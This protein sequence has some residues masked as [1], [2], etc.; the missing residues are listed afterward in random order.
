MASRE[1]PDKS[2]T[3]SAKTEEPAAVRNLQT[4]YYGPERRAA[5]NPRYFPLWNNAISIGGIFLIILAIILLLTFGLFNL[6]TPT[7]NP[8]VDIVGYLILPVLLVAGLLI[9]PVGI[10]FKSWRLHR[11]DPSQKLAFRFPRIDLNDPVQRRAAKFVVGLTFVMLPVA[12][13]SGYHG[14]HYTDSTE[15]CA[16]AC[17]SVMEPQATAYE[18]SPHARV[19]CAECH[20]GAGASWFVKSKLSGTRQVFATWRDSYQRPIPPAITHLRPAR[21]TCERCHW[22]KKFYGA[23]LTRIVNYSS[24]QNNTRAKIDM[25]LKIGGGDESSGRAEGIHMHMALAGRIDYIATDDKLQVI[26][27]VRMIDDNGSELIYRSDGRP[28]TDPLPEGRIRQ[29]DCM[30]CHNRPAHKFRSPQR[31]VDIYLDVGNIDT[32]LPYIKR[33]AVAVLVVDYPDVQSAKAQIGRHL[34]DFYRQNYPDIWQARKASVDQAIDKVR[35]IYSTNFFPDMQVDWQTYPDNIGHKNS[36]GCFRCHAGDHVNQYGERISHD[37]NIC[38]TFLNAVEQNDQGGLIQEGEF[39]HPVK[40]AGRH[41]DLRCHQCHSG[42]LAPVAT[43]EGCHEKQQGFY[44]ATLAQLSEFNIEKDPMFGS[45]GCESCHD[46]SE[47][48]SLE[49]VDMQCLDCHEDEEEEYEGLLARWSDD[50]IKKRVEA[51]SAMEELM[52]WIDTHR[53]D[54]IDGQAAIAWV[55]RSRP[56]VQLLA[57][58]GPLHNYAAAISIYE[59]LAAEATQY[60]TKLQADTDSP[61]P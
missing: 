44:G 45:V 24:D 35:E 28:S 54:R 30:D 40:L 39:I 59:T 12:G 41:T 4:A 11:R 55:N 46:L 52:V 21:E 50:V 5:Y 43:C 34:A 23:Q 47:P 9:T 7:A 37:C 42:G 38:H 25:L 8:Y 61:H 19:S 6:I 48:L 13:I 29:L 20:I 16:Y 58:A 18:R 15:F 3:A 22:P 26:P 57:E 60:L 53:A 49:A 1:D 51:H 17:H 31:A 14:Y 10:L 36:A 33:E 32:T 56:M 27:W 2:P